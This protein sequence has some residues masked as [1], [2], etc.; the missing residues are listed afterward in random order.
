ME[1]MGSLGKSAEQQVLMDIDKVAQAIW[2]ADRCRV[3]GCRRR[4]LGGW[5]S[6]DDRQQDIYR[7][8]AQAAVDAVST[9]QPVD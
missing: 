5:E 7:R 2:G 8:M 6:L 9:R 4:A 3:H 1:A